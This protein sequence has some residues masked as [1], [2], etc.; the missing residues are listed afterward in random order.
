[1]AYDSEKE[2]REDGKIL[3]LKLILFLERGE[4]EEDES[5]QS[6]RKLENTFGFVWKTLSS[7]V[8]CFELKEI[9]ETL[10]RK[11]ENPGNES[12]FSA[13]HYHILHAT[14]ALFDLELNQFSIQSAMK[15]SIKLA[16]LVGIQFTDRYSPQKVSRSLPTAQVYS[17]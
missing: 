4:Q 6:I 2:C 10:S 7:M 5:Q 9:F 8:H 3:P 16:R 13:V 12:K 14:N 11:L 1:V 17:V 15:I